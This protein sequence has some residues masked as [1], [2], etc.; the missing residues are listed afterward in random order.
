MGHGGSI[1]SPH[2]QYLSGQA[3][4]LGLQPEQVV[5]PEQLPLLVT[6]PLHRLKVAPGTLP[7]NNR[8]LQLL[9]GGGGGGADT[10]QHGSAMASSR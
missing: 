10:R 5:H 8:T 3:G 4:P 9:Q 6:C 2:L 7:A 1:S